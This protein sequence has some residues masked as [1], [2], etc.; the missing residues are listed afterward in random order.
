MTEREE[1]VVNWTHTIRN[2]R[3]CGKAVV[4]GDW[5]QDCMEKHQ[6]EYV[7]RLGPK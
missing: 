4:D 5:H 3:F 2:C 7:K 1:Y 6:E